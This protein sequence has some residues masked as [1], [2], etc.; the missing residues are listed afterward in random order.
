[1]AKI[2]L[3]KNELKAQRDALKRFE[4]YLPTLQ[5]KK[6]QLQLEVR[7]VREVL[8]HL[9]AEEETFREQLEE[10]IKILDPTRREQLEQ[11]LVVERLDTGVRNIAG[12]DTPTFEG[13]TFR[14]IPY[15][16][17]ATPP[18]YDEVLSA[19]KKLVEFSL[20][21]SIVEEQL[22][23]VEQELRVVTQRVNLFE[24]VKIP[25][26]KE[27]IRRIQ[28]YL[29]DQQTNAVGRAKI[30]KEKC[31]ARDAATVGAAT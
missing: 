11:L 1:M 3:T 17:Y 29:G 5:L 28:I 19:A 20:R 10:W 24:K 6:Q 8:R 26:A 2:K 15:D 27:N 31:S 25:E 4:R 22:R 12:I 21:R 14:K 23:L 30:A 9:D 13:V 16:L 18:W 7:L